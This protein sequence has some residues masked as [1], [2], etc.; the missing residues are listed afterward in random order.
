MAN[1]TKIERKKKYY[2]IYALVFLW[3]L[4]FSLPHYIQTS[5][6]EQFVALD[7]VGYITMFASIVVLIVLVVYPKLIKKYS[8]YSVT[9]FILILNIINVLYLISVENT[10]LVLISYTIQAV[11]IFLLFINMDI[12][13]EDSSEDRTTGRVRTIYM[14]FMHLAVIIGALAMG[15]IAGNADRYWLVYLIAGIILVPAVVILVV[16]HKRLKDH[17]RYEDRKTKDLIKIFAKNRDLRNVLFIGFVNRFFYAVMALFVPIFFHQE[18]GFSWWEISIMFTVML[19]PF[20]IFQ[21]PAGNLA[22]RFIG[23]KEILVFGLIVMALSVGAMF[24]IQSDSLI[25]WTAVLVVTRIG[26]S[27]VEAMIDVYFFKTVK[28]KDIDVINFFRGARPAA[29][30]VVSLVSIVILAFFD[31][32]YMFLFLA[33]L[34]L[35]G[36]RPALALH[37]TK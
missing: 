24:F 10:G 25:A 28:K 27:L 19:L 26:A 21:M 9:M 16:Q 15:F 37:D 35:I 31:I 32:S 2:L 20:I 34:L 8:N 14:F 12:F 1:L 7:K 11:T 4:S 36:V 13:L 5:F 22:D 23:E 17:V 29:W 3:A 6:L 30:I 33:V 18:I